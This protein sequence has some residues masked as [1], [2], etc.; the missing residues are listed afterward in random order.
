LMPSLG[1]TVMRPSQIPYALS[2]GSA[3]RRGPIGMFKALNHGRTL[4]L[5]GLAELL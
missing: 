4:G 2:A 1:V 5:R 3:Q